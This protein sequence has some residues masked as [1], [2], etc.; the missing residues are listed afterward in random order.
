MKPRPTQGVGGLGELMAICQVV[1]A[2]VS[3]ISDVMISDI[4]VVVVSETTT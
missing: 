2:A 1:A 3:V 4:V